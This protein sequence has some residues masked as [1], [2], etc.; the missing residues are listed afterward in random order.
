MSGLFPGGLADV[1]GFLSNDENIRDG[2]I[3]VG[4]SL[5]GSPGVTRVRQSGPYKHAFKKCIFFMFL[6]KKH[7]RIFVHNYGRV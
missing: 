3:T 4:H 2:K 5:D 1:Q 7:K 6:S